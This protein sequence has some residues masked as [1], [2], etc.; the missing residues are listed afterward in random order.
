M[1]T[2]DYCL[3][4]RDLEKYYNNKKVTAL[5]RISFQVKYGK[6]FGFGAVSGADLQVP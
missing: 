4:V 1:S 5:D 3:S 2:D 6:V